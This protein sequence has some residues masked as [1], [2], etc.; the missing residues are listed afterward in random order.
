MRIRMTQQERALIKE[1][2]L[3]GPSGNKTWGDVIGDGK[4]KIKKIPRGK[5]EEGANNLLKDLYKLQ[6]AL[7]YEVCEPDDDMRCA[8]DDVIT[9][10]EEIKEIKQ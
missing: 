7:E 2:L 9:L 8:L 1:K 6:E 3:F 5:N 10:M 4:M